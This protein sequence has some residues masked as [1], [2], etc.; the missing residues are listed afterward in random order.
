MLHLAV[1][2]GQLRVNFVCLL[3][4]LRKP[5]MLTQSLVEVFDQ[6]LDDSNSNGWQG[7]QAVHVKMMAAGQ[8]MPPASVSL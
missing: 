2:Y 3:T 7:L 5:F 4:M 1:C 8:G 6:V